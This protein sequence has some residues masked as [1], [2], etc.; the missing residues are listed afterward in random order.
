ME[1]YVWAVSENGI[2]VMLL[3]FA[4][5]LAILVGLAPGYWFWRLVLVGVAWLLVPTSFSA[6]QEPR[7]P[8]ELDYG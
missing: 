4:S 3:S 7:P 6:R 1:P 8:N 2:Y 5:L